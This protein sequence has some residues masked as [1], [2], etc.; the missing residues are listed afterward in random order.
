M[1]ARAGWRPVGYPVRMTNGIGPRRRRRI[2]LS[3]NEELDADDWLAGYRPS[4]DDRY[5]FDEPGFSTFDEPVPETVE[6]DLP[7]LGSIHPPPV[8]IDPLAKANLRAS[9]AVPNLSAAHASPAVPNSPNRGPAPGNRDRLPGEEP[10]FLGRPG[11]R[12]RSSATN[13]SCDS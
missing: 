4:P 8:V 13:R 7:S 1:T 12:L 2:G 10:I 6:A 5:D 9:P 11:R 3:H